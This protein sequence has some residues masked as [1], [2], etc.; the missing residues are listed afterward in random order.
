MSEVK[1]WVLG[2][3]PQGGHLTASGPSLADH[4]DIPAGGLPVRE[5]QATETDIK[6]VMKR[7]AG[8]RGLNWSEMST[9]H[10]EIYRD[11]AEQICAAVFGEEASRG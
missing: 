9:M 1:R 8:Q 2:W 10:R 3:N 4:G 5:D 7:L 11:E 6:A